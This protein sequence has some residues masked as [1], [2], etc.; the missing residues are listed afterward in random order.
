MGAG[1][2]G[3]QHHSSPGVCFPRENCPQKPDVGSSALPSPEVSSQQCWWRSAAPQH[4]S[5][6]SLAIAWEKG[7]SQPQTADLTVARVGIL[8]HRPAMGCL[9]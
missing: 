2:E 1:M 8:G 9:T 4:Q 6:G 5:L 7:S 3:A